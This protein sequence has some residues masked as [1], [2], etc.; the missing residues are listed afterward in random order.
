MSD[1]EP[2]SIRLN[3]SHRSDMVD[4]VM[5]E[6]VRQ[7]PAPPAASQTQLLEVIAP[8]LKKHAAIRRTTRLLSVVEGDDWNHMSLEHRVHAKVVN[9]KGNEVNTISVVYPL[10]IADRLGIP[11]V[12]TPGYALTSDFRREELSLSDID[13]V[14]DPEDNTVRVKVAQFVEQHYPTIVIDRDSEAMQARKAA[15]E[16][17]AEWEK[18]YQRLRR[19]TADLLDQ[20]A[21]TKQI[22]EGWPDIVPY[23]PPHIA[24]PERAVRLPVLT[25]SR[26]SERLGIKE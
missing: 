3:K 11:R 6:W 12:P 7:N 18:Q 23:I 4:A 15:R 10:S 25:T 26:L 21:T 9:N 14:I 1:K 13:E 16:A 5:A 8:E 2:R 22:R 20:F 17:L 24:D 19:E